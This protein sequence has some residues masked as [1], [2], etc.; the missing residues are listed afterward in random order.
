MLDRDQVANVIGSDVYGSDGEKIGTAG[1][2]YADDQTGELD[3]VTVNTGLFGIKESFVPLAEASFVDGRL[4]VPYDKAR[5]KGAP[6]VAG[7][8]H[9]SPEEEQELYAYY[10]LATAEPGSGGQRGDVDEQVGDAVEDERTTLASGAGRGGYDTSGPATDD[11]MTRSEEQLNVGTRTQAASRARLRKYVVTEEVTVT[12]PVRREKVV[13]EQEPLTGGEAAG[14]TTG[15]S[16]DEGDAGTA[17]GQE[18]SEAELTAVGDRDLSAG[19]EIILHEEVPVVHMGVREVER[20]RLG[21]EQVTE[22]RVV[23]E[24]VRKERA[25]VDGDVDPSSSQSEPDR[26]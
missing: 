1:E 15:R 14:A 8:V 16:S 18:L 24:E 21:T 17:G 3:W 11:A 12:V 4:V 13:L 19:D 26:T 22:E 7:E 5:V 9:L 2:I 10:G 23:T 20:V 25:E 6:S